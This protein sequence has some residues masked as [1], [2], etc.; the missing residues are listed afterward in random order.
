M[1]WVGASAGRR[2]PQ[3]PP[4]SERRLGLQRPVQLGG[5]EAERVLT[6][7]VR[8]RRRGR[9]TLSRKPSRPVLA[10]KYKAAQFVLAP[11]GDVGSEPRFHIQ[12]SFLGEE[13]RRGRRWLWGSPSPSAGCP[14]RPCCLH[15]WR[16]SRPDWMQPWVA[17][18]ACCGDHTGWSLALGFGAGGSGAARPRER[19]S[20]G[21]WGAR[22]GKAKASDRRR[23]DS[24][25][26]VLCSA[27]KRSDLHP[28]L[29]DGDLR[30]APAHTKRVCKGKGVTQRGVGPWERA[31]EGCLRLGSERAGAAVGARAVSVAEAASCRLDLKVTVTS[32]LPQVLCCWSSILRPL[33]GSPFSVPAARE[34]SPSISLIRICICPGVKETISVPRN[35]RLGFSFPS[36]CVCQEQVRFLPRGC[37]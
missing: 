32:D 12:V 2:D 26:D 33:S 34:P 36:R 8:L 4:N 11:P 27:G 14:G 21:T 23:R 25:W 29:G 1:L 37:I 7:F 16:C 13:G 24:F 22:M 17:G 28:P 10:P 18:R 30:E 15:P 31:G 20:D 35:F 19:V 5:N 3:P 6:H 9:A